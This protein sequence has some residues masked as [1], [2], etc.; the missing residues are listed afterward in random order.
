[1]CH[2]WRS[3]ATFFFGMVSRFAHLGGHT[4]A[5]ERSLYAAEHHILEELWSVLVLLDFRVF[6]QPKG[7][8]PM[9]S[10]VFL[11][12]GTVKMDPVKGAR[13]NPAFMSNPLPES[14]GAILL[15]PKMRSHRPTR[16][17]MSVAPGT[18]LRAPS[19]RG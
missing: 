12:G 19:P 13:Q 7:C 4:S 2:G 16:H 17:A 9:A 14:R 8:A 15:G 18:A 6:L 3:K 10:L 1:M 5:Q 11:P